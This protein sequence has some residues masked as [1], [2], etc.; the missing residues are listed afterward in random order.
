MAV[1]GSWKIE[2]ISIMPSCHM[3]HIFYNIP[4]GEFNV[5]P[6]PK[7]ISTY[8]LYLTVIDCPSTDGG[9]QPLISSCRDDDEKKKNQKIG[10]HYYYPPPLDHRRP[11]HRS[12]FLPLRMFPPPQ[13]SIAHHTGSQSQEEEA[14]FPFLH[15]LQVHF[16]HG[17]E[18]IEIQVGQTRTTIQQQGSNR[19]IRDQNESQSEEIQEG[20]KGRG[21]F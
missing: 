14:A 3:Y 15:K 4:D 16:H 12:H 18:T 19:N 20:G 7:F 9:K 13:L 5:L 17:R 1:V 10:G 6:S 11:F 21:T 2:K 8:Y